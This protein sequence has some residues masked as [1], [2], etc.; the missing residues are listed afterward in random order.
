MLLGSGRTLIASMAQSLTHTKIE[1]GCG[2][3]CTLLSSRAAISRIDG[4]TA[5]PPGVRG[6]ANQEAPRMALKAPGI[7]IFLLSIILA[8]AVLFTKFFGATVPLL[9]GETTQFYGLLLAYIILVFGCI[10]RGL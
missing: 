2:R 5:L 3:S 4:N 7:L 9:S 8:L 6:R 1:T 10:M